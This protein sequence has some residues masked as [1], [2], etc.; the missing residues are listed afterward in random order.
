MKCGHCDGTGWLHVNHCKKRHATQAE[1][2]TVGHCF[3]SCGADECVAACECV[4]LQRA[5]DTAAE[6]LAF[7][8]GQVPETVPFYQSQFDVAA[9]AL[10]DFM[11]AK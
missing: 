4:G 11:E 1:L 5:H 7:A 8:K 6:E 2:D 3:T 10:H 9:T